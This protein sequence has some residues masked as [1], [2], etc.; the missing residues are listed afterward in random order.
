MRAWWFLGK[1]TVTITFY[2]G[3]GTWRAATH[4]LLL[5]QQYLLPRRD[6]K[7]I[8]HANIWQSNIARGSLFCGFPLKPIIQQK[9]FLKY[10]IHDRQRQKCESCPWTT[11]GYELNLTLKKRIV[12]FYKREFFQGLL[13]KPFL[14]IIPY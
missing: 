5:N 12:N 8:I 10:L 9:T 2:M 6:Q 3:P 13:W 4:A 1:D 14:W 7:K 11:H